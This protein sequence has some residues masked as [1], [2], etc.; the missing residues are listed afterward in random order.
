MKSTKAITLDCGILRIELQRIQDRWQHVIGVVRD[1]NFSALAT[2]IEGASDDHWPASPALQELHVEQRGDETAAMLMGMAGTSHWSVS[3]LGQPLMN[4]AVVD[5]ACR[6]RETPAWLG[7]LYQT[8][9]WLTVVHGE[10]VVELQ[11]PHDTVRVISRSPDLTGS[12]PQLSSDCDA[13]WAAAFLD[14]VKE[15]GRSFFFRT[16]VFH[17]RPSSNYPMVV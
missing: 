13:A 7:S 11:I 4:R 6:C 12:I 14:R 9:E 8:P 10:D 3:I 5:V 15:F 1:S 17:R 2:S 16:A